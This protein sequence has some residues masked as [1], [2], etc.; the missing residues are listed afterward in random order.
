MRN[1][2]AAPALF[3][4]T[5]L[6]LPS[7]V[8]AGTNGG[9]SVTPSPPVRATVSVLLP[10]A[11]LAMNTPAVDDT[12]L[13]YAMPTAFTPTGV[14]LGGPVRLMGVP[15]QAT[16]HGLR[17]GSPH[18][19]CTI[20]GLPDL[21]VAPFSSSGGWVVYGAYENSN[22][23][24]W[25]LGFCQVATGRHVVLDTSARE[26]GGDNLP[27]TRSDGRTIIW[28]T[29]TQAPG[30]RRPTSIVRTYD[31]TTGKQRVLVQGGDPRKFVYGA[32]SVSGRRALVE[33]QNYVG[34]ET[35]EFLLADLD[36][37]RLRPLGAPR[38]D[39]YGPTLSGETVAYG[40]GGPDANGGTGGVGVG[41]YDVPTGRRVEI[42]G[43]IVTSQQAVAGH[44][45]VYVQGVPPQGL[46][47]TLW[48]YDLRTGRRTALVRPDMPRYYGAGSEVFS[49]G[50]IVAYVRGLP[51]V[52][53]RPV[54]LL[55]L[56]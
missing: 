47:S 25:T 22:T 49:G 7:S 41:A 21:K 15:L 43:S 19:I 17:A 1:I 10:P 54:V 13:A 37:G 30:Q 8:C 55:L 11:A 48:L 28:A 53:Q 5:L 33:K 50:H 38:H 24:L 32:V 34:L 46:V 44:D 9:A 6:L 20:T 12:L 4:L 36:T 45:I 18:P 14:S 29:Q 23:A 52:R 40:V 31:L 51:H 56:A 27:V 35:D 42:T 26:R 2:L 3:I 16:A 39:I